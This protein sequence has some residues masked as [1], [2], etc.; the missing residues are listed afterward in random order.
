MI[1]IY[2]FKMSILYP[3]CASC[4][5]NLD[6]IK[7]NLIDLVN[8]I[9][10]NEKIQIVDTSNYRSCCRYKLLTYHLIFDDEF[11]AISNHIN[12]KNLTFYNIFHI[13]NISNDS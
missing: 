3:L 1:V 13:D 8:K 11:A 5:T 4:G 9:P 6:R 10:P 12:L 2:N 7:R